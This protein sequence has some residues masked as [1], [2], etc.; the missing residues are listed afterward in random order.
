MP[1][2]RS[3][4]GNSFVARL[5]SPKRGDG[6]IVVREK[7]T[8]RGGVSVHDRIAPLVLELIDHVAALVLL[9]SGH[10]AWPA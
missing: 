10:A 6:D 3:D 1:S 8:Q 9:C 5:Q 7:R 2:T 4:A